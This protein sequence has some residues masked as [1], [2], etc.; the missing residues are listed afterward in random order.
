MLT[1]FF[2]KSPAD[3]SFNNFNDRSFY[4]IARKVITPRRR[5]VCKLELLL[6]YQ[7]LK[8]IVAKV[9]LDI[10]KFTCDIMLQ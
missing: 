9:L 4:L 3:M 8:K 2:S 5:H 7:L 1:V 10:I 6:L